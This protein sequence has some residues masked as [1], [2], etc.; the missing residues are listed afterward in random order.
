MTTVKFC[1]RELG[2]DNIAFDCNNYVSKVCA[3]ILLQNLSVISGPNMTVEIN[4]R[5]VKSEFYSS[6]RSW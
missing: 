5:Y 1:E 4:D 6:N 2:I 3:S